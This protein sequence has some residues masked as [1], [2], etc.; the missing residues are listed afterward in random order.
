MWRGPRSFTGGEVIL[1]TKRGGDELMGER[2]PWL[3]FVGRHDG[4]GRASTLVFVDAPT[5]PGHPTRWFVRA[6]PFACACP[7]PFFSAEV[8]VAP[9]GT[10]TLSY[11]VI[12]ADGT[13]D[14][15]VLAARQ[16]A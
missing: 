10:L 7:A 15:A 9:G 3:A 2:A 14:P 4:H 13:P 16:I 5:N 6:T 12:I 1:P 11:A 8:P